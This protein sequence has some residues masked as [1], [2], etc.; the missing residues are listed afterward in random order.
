MGEK[1]G[2]SWGWEGPKAEAL[3]ENSIVLSA[4]TTSPSQSGETALYLHQVSPSCM[5]SGGPRAV[6]RAGAA[7]RIASLLGY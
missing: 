1:G 3:G 6:Q 7:T 5:Q 2:S 4:T